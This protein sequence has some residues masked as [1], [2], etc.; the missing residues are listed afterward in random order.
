MITFKEKKVAITQLTTNS[1][2]FQW[3]DVLD[4]T[5]EEVD[6]LS[7]TYH[8]HHY[9]LR[10]CLEPDHLPKHEQLEDANFLI[11]RLLTGE[12]NQEADSIQEM[13]N[14]VAIFYNKK[15]LITIHRRP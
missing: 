3:I 5:A 14:K 4:P 8:L 11:T 10:D 6:Q 7:K 12:T 13:T 2:N 1:E 9:T 15:F